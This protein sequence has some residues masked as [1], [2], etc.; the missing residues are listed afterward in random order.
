M[1]VLKSTP[2][3]AVDVGR[4][5]KRGRRR[6]GRAVTFVSGGG[7]GAANAQQKVCQ[8]VPKVPKISTVAV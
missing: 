4:L 7:T 5:M 3:S 6:S 1:I 2:T 8:A